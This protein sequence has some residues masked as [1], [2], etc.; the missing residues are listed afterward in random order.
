MTKERFDRSKPNVNIGT[1]GRESGQLSLTDVLD[2]MDNRN[3][4]ELKVTN[5]FT[6]LE[7]KRK[8]KTSKNRWG[9][10]YF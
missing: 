3:S 7:K 8:K 10:K 9:K 2:L 4:E 5:K 1:I 6:P